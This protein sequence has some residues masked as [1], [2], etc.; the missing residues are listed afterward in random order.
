[1]DDADLQPLVPPLHARARRGGM[2]MAISHERPILHVIDHALPRVTG[3]S[4]RSHNLLRHLR[5]AGVPLLVVASSNVPGAASEDVV[6][7]VAYTRLPLRVP[8]SH[9]TPATLA[10]RIA[11]LAR[12]LQRCIGER[13][14]ALVH[15]HSPV[16]NG[17]AALWAARR[18]GVPVIYE[19]RAL[20]EDA[21]V[22]RGI[23]T[24]G[25]LRYRG[26]RGLETWLL[27]NVDAVTT[28][29]R[30]LLADIVGRGVPADRVF[31]TPNAIDC[32]LFRPAP[33]DAE[34][35]ARHGLTGAVVFGYLGY[36]FA[37]EGVED[38]V[39][40]FARARAKLPRARLLFVGGG[41]GDESLRTLVHRLGLEP[42]VTFTGKVPHAS[43]QRYYSLCDV[44]VYPRRS[45]RTTNLVTP[46]KP[47]EAMAMGKP[48][49]VSDVGGLR[50]LVGANE[51]GLFFPSSDIERLADRLI[52]LGDDAALRA[53]LGANARRA[54]TERYSWDRVVDVYRQAYGRLLGP[55]FDA[56]RARS[57][58]PPNPGEP[59]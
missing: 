59:R 48:I 47:L 39:H 4:V 26:A 28:I 13:Q 30:G 38:L 18:T 35:I 5:A 23:G 57:T 21:A 27:R 56:G 11:R 15:A 50:E 36:F 7:G 40:A 53:R 12:W 33:A 20:W 8:D 51:T 9:Q 17:I 41:D 44:L 54:A 31:H 1:V 34:L 25:S 22:A 14:V 3:Y 49:V 42:A 43:V 16:I 10:V 55:A 32:D 52:A 46:L 19:M 58:S 29:S 2:T 45:N 6:D 37:Y 24:P